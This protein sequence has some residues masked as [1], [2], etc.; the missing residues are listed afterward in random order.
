MAGC[1]CDVQGRESF[2]YF[3]LGG[4][5]GELEFGNVSSAMCSDNIIILTFCTII[6]MPASRVDK[7][8]ARRT[9]CRS[10]KNMVEQFSTVPIN[11]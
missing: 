1:V 10:P 2:F 8:S 7:F 5:L 11:L 4:V 3:L 9:K 6:K